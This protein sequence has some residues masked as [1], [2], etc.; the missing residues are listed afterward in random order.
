MTKTVNKITKNGHVY[1]SVIDQKWV[2]GKIVRRYVGYLGKSPN[3]K[4]EVELG[5]LLPYIT[6]L[7]NKGVSQEDLAAK[8]LGPDGIALLG[9]KHFGFEIDYKGTGEA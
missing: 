3:S 6:R 9:P 1:Y 4:R 8:F 2:K 7:L 5:D